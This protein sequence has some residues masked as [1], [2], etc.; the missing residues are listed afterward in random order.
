MFSQAPVINKS[1]LNSAVQV[2]FSGTTGKLH[3]NH[4]NSISK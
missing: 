4:T 2:N 1:T 3:D